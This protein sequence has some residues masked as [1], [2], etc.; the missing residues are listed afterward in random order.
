[1]ENTNNYFYPQ[2]PPKL[3][4]K[5]HITDIITNSGNSQI[6]IIKC[7]TKT[8]IQDNKRILKIVHKTQFQKKIYKVISCLESSYIQK[9]IEIIYYKNNYYIITK[10]QLNLNT[11]ITQKGITQNDILDIASDISSSL[12]LLHSKKILHLDCTPSNRKIICWA[13]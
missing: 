11:I 3:K 12:G 1:M 13:K 8:R 6:Y 9:P 4:N 10:Y 5:W 7:N 2:L